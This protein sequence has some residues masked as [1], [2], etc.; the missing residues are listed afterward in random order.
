MLRTPVFLQILLV[1]CA[2]LLPLGSWAQSAL[3]AETGAGI[4][5]LE[6]RLLEA[7]TASD[8][9]EADKNALIDL[10]RKAI[11]QLEQRRAY[12]SSSAEF[13]Q[14]RE[15]APKKSADLRAQLEKLESGAPQKLPDSLARKSLPQLEQQL[16]GEKADLTTLGAALTELE[17]LLETQS[18]RAQLARERLA[19]AKKRQPEISEAL[20]APVPDGQAQ[21]LTEA[22]RWA[23]ELEARALAAE[24][25]MLE[26]ELL[27]QPMRVELL[28]AQRD[29]ATLELS[30]QTQYIEL[31]E[32]LVVELRL[33]E[34]ETV[35]EA[36]EQ[37]ERKAFG[38]HELV[39]DLAQRNT[40]LGEELK[41]LAVELE[42]LFSKSP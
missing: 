40:R 3:P 35:S 34:A 33:S 2:S 21:R 27:S 38:K 30:R 31:L 1:T 17:G 36:A 5:M 14:A 19:E 37:T 18:K 6:N 28:G 39:Q 7:E 20:Q 24:I 42:P 12:E 10:Y 13:A 9:N 15:T 22:R 16:L 25:E 41:S 26:Q 4:E 23:L 8:L 32:S 11:G 29:K